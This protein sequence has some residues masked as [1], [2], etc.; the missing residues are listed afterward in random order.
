MRGTLLLTV[1][2]NLWP[3]NAML[4]ASIHPSPSTRSSSAPSPLVLSPTC[5]WTP[6]PFAQ[7]PSCYWGLPTHLPAYPT[8]ACRSFISRLLM[9]LLSGPSSLVPP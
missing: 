2:A 7:L 5:Y 6:P 8:H 4:P 9:P 3:A 1:P